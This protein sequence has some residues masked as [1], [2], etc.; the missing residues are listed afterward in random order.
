MFVWGRGDGGQ[1]GFEL[2]E[3]EGIKKEQGIDSPE[4]YIH[5]PVE[6]PFNYQDEPFIQAACGEA[7]TILLSQSGVAY[8]WG[9]NSNGQLGLGFSGENF[10]A[11]LGNQMSQ[12]FSS[13]QIRGLK[14]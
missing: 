14:G 5:Y 12:V 1:L 3:I 4:I 6:L 13:R 9:W 11:G 2:D 7:H 8:G 10:E